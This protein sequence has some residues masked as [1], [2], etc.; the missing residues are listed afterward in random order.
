MKKIAV[1]AVAFMAIGMSAMAQRGG[2]FGREG[3]DPAQIKAKLSQTYQ[4][5]LGFTKAKADTVAGVEAAFAQKIRAS[6]QANQ[7][8]S[9]EELRTQM[10]TL[11]QDKN[12]Q[13]KALLTEDE[14]KKL[15]DYNQNHA[16]QRGGMR[17]GPGG[18][19]QQVEN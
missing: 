9:R 12:T 6:F 4:D 18:Q 15:T 2:G 8:G 11:N 14:F 13:I 17:G 10:Q 3:G 16:R 5:S 1:L 7:G 19:R